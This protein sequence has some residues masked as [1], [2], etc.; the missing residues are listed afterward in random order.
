[1]FRGHPN[2]RCKGHWR[3]WVV[4]DWGAGYGKDPCHIW[5]FVELEGMPRGR[6]A[7]E[8]GGTALEDGVY[9]VVEWA[10]Y[11]DPRTTDKMTD[12]FTPLTL[13][14]GGVD[15]EG[16]V[17]S[18]SFF[19]ANVEAFVKTCIVIPDVGGPVNAY[20]EVKPRSLWANEFIGWLRRP[21]DE[22]TMDWDDFEEEKR[23]IEE[24]KRKKQEEKERKELE[25]QRKALEKQQK[26]QLEKQQQKQQ[27]ELEKQRNK[28][29]QRKQQ[30][31]Q[32]ASR[33]SRKRKSK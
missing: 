2:Y 5:C 10:T 19:L 24:E 16:R 27:N 6:S 3:D 1:M 23:K 9:A 25:K 22:D 29:Q 12:L 28:E 18:R 26:K 33:N 4:V 11:D 17:T 32:R 13:D 7:L 30:E 15:C 14:V 8:F 20:F 21:H 31:Q